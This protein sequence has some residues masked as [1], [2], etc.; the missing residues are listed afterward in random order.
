MHDTPAMVLL[1]APVR[2]KSPS[3]AMWQQAAVRNTY[4]DATNTALSATGSTSL[5]RASP[6]RVYVTSATSGQPFGHWRNVQW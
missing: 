4:T 6:N 5:T 3:T 1:V 2:T